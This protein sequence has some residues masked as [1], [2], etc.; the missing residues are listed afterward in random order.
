MQAGVSKRR[1]LC[2]HMGFHNLMTMSLDVLLILLMILVI[3]VRTVLFSGNIQ[4]KTMKK[5][6]QT[7]R[8]NTAEINTK[9]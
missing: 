3:L 2:Y 1:F 6:H 4:Q 5:Q 7:V 9:S 8:T